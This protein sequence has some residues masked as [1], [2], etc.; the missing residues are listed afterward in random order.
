MDLAPLAR[1]IVRYGAGAL[2]ARGL[3]SAD[4]GGQ[5]AVDP[6]VISYVDLGLGLALAGVTEFYYWLARK[7]GW[8][9]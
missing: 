6:D 8:A 7:F 1:I 3:L 5:L 9:K 2:V 4:S